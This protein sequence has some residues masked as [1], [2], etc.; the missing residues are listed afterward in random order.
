MMSKFVKVKVKP[1]SAFDK[2]ERMEDGS[3]LIHTKAKAIDGKANLSIIKM[4]SKEFNVNFKNI[5]IKNPK[6]RKKI[7]EIKP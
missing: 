7:I 4:I 1:G 6:S 3:Y 5:L 2:V